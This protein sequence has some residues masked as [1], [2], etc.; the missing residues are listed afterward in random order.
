MAESAGLLVVIA[1]LASVPDVAVVEIAR[2]R[3]ELG[4]ILL[5]TGDASGA[6]E[7]LSIVL[8]LASESWEFREKA[9]RRLARA[10]QQR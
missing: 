3:F 5:V 6:E 7:H 9:E 4:S 10:R 1:L 2:L 8:R